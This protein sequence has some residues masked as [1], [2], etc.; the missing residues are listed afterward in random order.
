MKASGDTMTVGGF[1]DHFSGHATAYRAARPLYPAA[2]FDW[3]AAEAPSRGLAWDAGCGN[4]QASVALAER[5]ERVL[6]TD[7]S[8]PQIANAEPHPRIDYRAEPA[9]ASTLM[10]RSV[11]LVT[12]AQA[13]HWLDPVR[14]HAEVRRV[15]KPGALLAAWTYGLCS[16]TPAIDAVVH[17][18]YEDIVG[19]YWPPERRH[20]ES[21]Y[22]TL[23][24]PLAEVAAPAFSMHADWTLP[25]FLAY[26]RTWSSV[27]RYATMN[28]TDPV[29][30][31]DA[32]LAAAWG[33]PQAARKLHWPLA[34][35]SGRID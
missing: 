34:V 32:E 6:A 3:L 11:D 1:K 18:L 35:R 17:R 33:E 2:L 19:P 23:L 8:A 26:L 15:A 29:G 5:F 27:Q 31:V 10:A 20:I 24:W 14:F 22:S 16:I 30:M 7:P 13:Y 25:Q 4:G 12:V 28:G 9:E 21:G